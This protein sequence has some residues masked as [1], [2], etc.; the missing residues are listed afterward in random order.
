[1]TSAIVTANHLREGGV[2]WL[3][4]NMSWTVARDQAGHFAGTR[5]EHARIVAARSE[6]AN[7][8]T[9]VYE[10]PIDG[11]TEKSAREMIRALRG[12]TITPPPDI[13]PVDIGSVDIGPVDIDPMDICSGDR[14]LV[15]G[16][17]GPVRHSNVSL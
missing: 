3:A 2:V 8:V 15:G 9:G 6:A 10:V 5:L 11:K 16:D 13:G 14:P 1:M 17:T 7:I 4:G 12:P